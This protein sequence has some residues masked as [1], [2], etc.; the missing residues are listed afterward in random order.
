[1]IESAVIG[2][3]TG[4]VLFQNTDLQC[5]V[6]VGKVYSFANTD[7]NRIF[8]GVVYYSQ[9]TF[10]PT[11]FPT[12]VPSFLPTLRPS[13]ATQ[14][15]T[16][17]PTASPSISI[18]PTNSYPDLKTTYSGDQ[19]NYGNMFELVS[20]GDII[21]QAF[22]VHSSATSDKDVEIY[23]RDGA[24]SDFRSPGAWVK[25][26]LEG[27]KVTGKGEFNRPH[28]ISTKVDLVLISLGC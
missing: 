18:A 27:L 21:I 25:I 23:S 9:G 17:A 13:T 2:I 15:P 8:N 12:S 20:R 10:P 6:G 22:D 1:M 5:K 7:L 11:S 26:S 4:A 3:S 16:S 28:D 19:S 14:K 24:L